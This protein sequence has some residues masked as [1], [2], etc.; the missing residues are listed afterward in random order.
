[1]ASVNQ[2]QCSVLHPLWQ[3]LDSSCCLELFWFLLKLEQFKYNVWRNG[4][5]PFPSRAGKDALR[6]SCCTRLCCCCARIFSFM[7][8]VRTRESEGL[9]SDVVP[10]LAVLPLLWDAAESKPPELL[11]EEL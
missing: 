11:I 4:H 1:M 2:E 9:Q 8:F 5:V 3:P 6:Q 7:P 10:V